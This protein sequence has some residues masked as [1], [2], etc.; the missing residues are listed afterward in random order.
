MHTLS[1]SECPNII[2]RLLC[3]E[4]FIPLYFIRST[5][6][7]RLLPSTFDTEIIE[8]HFY[9]SYEELTLSV[10]TENSNGEYHLK[11]E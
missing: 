11:K 9:A 3:F 6:L 10:H 2:G 4:I 5:I 7:I 8:F 1:K